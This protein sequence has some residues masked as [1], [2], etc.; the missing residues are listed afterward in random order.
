MYLISSKTDALLSNNSSIS[1]LD[2]VLS[3]GDTINL[4][5]LSSLKA[6]MDVPRKEGISITTDKD[7]ISF[8][9]YS[10]NNKI[11][12]IRISRI[13]YFEGKDSQVKIKMND[14]E[15]AIDFYPFGIDKFV[16]PLYDKISLAKCINIDYY[17]CEQ[18][19]R[20]EQGDIYFYVDSYG[21]E[22]RY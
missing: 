7:S 6:G 5:N 17:T 19:Y 20:V 8:I 12:T 4:L 13:E 14:S 1:K 16:S 11:F 21:N 2:S 18:I 15:G 9:N 3:Y 22:F 10:D